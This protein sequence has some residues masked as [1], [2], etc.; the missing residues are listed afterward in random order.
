[1]NPAEYTI[2]QKADIEVRVKKAQDFLKELN[3][4]PSSF[5]SPVNTGDDVFALKVTSY[6]QDTKYTSPVQRKD[7]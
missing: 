1:M 5:V 7:L 2:E 3:L 6:L 4:Q